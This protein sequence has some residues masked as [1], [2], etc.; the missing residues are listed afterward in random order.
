MPGIKSDAPLRPEKKLQARLN[1]LCATAALPLPQGKQQSNK[2]KRIAGMVMQLDVNQHGYKSLTITFDGSL[3]ITYNDGT[4]DLLSCGYGQW[5]YSP[6][7][8]FP[9]YSINA[10][11]RMRDLKHDFVAAAA[12]AWTSP[13]TLVVRVHYV[14]WISGTTFTFDFE[15]NEV[16]MCDNFPSS[17]PETVHFLGLRN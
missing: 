10:V 15:K 5:R 1:Q 4:Q 13:T 9:P 7:T 3:I 6:M 17:K 11:N 12:H 2:G 14:N 8:G 16:T